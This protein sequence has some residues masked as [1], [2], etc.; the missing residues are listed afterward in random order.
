[1]GKQDTFYFEGLDDILIAMM[2]TP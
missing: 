2:A 1:M